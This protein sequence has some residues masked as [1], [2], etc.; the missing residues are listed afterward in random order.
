M[1]V[2]KYHTEPLTYIRLQ[3]RADY[4]NHVPV[5]IDDN[6]TW[7]EPLEDPDEEEAEELCPVCK[8]KPASEPEPNQSTLEAWF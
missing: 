1:M 4:W 3:S 5:L 2:T 7:D 8:P 6:E